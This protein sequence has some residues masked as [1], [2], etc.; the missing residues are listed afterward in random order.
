MKMKYKILFLFIIALIS[1]PSVIAQNKVDVYFFYGKTCPHC[2]AERMFLESIQDKYPTLRIH[3]FEIY[4]NK[5]NSALF[6]KMCEAYGTQPYGVPMTFIGEHYQIGYGNDATTGKEIEALIAQ[7]MKVSCVNPLEMISGGEKPVDEDIEIKQKAIEISKKNSKVQELLEKNP[8][9]VPSV[10]IDDVY[11]VTWA[12]KTDVIV[13]HIDKNTE[14]IIKVLK[15]GLNIINVPLFGEVDVLKIGLPLFTF[16]IA[17]VDG[18]NPCTMWVLSFLLALLIYVHDRKKV[19]LVG[20]I[21]LIVVYIVYYL[22]MT[23]WLNL[24]LYIGYIDSVRIIIALIAIAAGLINMKD[25]IWF[26]KGIS[27]NIPDRFKP[28]LFQRM[29]AVIKEKAI[30]P[31]ILGTII[32]A[33]FAS[34]IELPCTSGFPAIYTKILTLQGFKGLSYYFYIMVYCS[35]YIIP[36]AVVIALFTYFMKGKKMSEKQGKILKLIGGFIMLVLGL[37]LLMKPELLMFG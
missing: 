10:K 6:F 19:I 30:I 28:K 1:I 29:R 3:E 5:E 9:I 15:Q 24:F 7:C 4:N 27:L 20:G 17:L 32:L 25:F 11:I 13:V 16:I 35:V 37:I 23:A 22:F 34:L 2:I 18:F 14:D 36:L 26:K 8:D 33:S 31:T 12:T 21:F